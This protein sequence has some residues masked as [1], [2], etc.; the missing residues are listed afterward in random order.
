[1]KVDYN[2]IF[3][4]I[5]IALSGSKKILWAIG[6]RAFLGVLVLI[7]LDMLLG[8][9]LFY[10]YVYLAENKVAQINGESLQF[11]DGV[12]QKVLNQWQAR[13]E[14]LNESLQKNYPNP[15]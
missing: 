12:Y 8:V 14:K 2:K 9:M 6:K 4:G 7:L 15:F 1:M 3:K 10:K 13:D 5:E 11:N